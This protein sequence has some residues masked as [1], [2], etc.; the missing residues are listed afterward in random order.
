MCPPSGW[1]HTRRPPAVGRA[2]PA[3]FV[4]PELRL[5]DEEQQGCMKNLDENKET[6]SQPER[7]Q[8]KS[9]ALAMAS[10][11]SRLLADKGFGQKPIDIVEALAFAMFVIADTYS[12]AKPDKDRARE[13]IHGFYGDMQNYFIQ[14]VIIADHQMSDATEIQS[15]SDQFHDLSRDRFGQYGEKFKQ[16]ISDPMALSCPITVSSLLDNL[17]IQPITKQEKLELMGAV[18]DRVL[19][20]WTG[21]VQ[22]FT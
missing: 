20:F 15:V 22:K 17:F 8:L 7:K 16:D 14:K 6:N 2:L 19:A 5:G 18:S 10:D 21:C 4:V 12:L 11:I 3:I 1:A 9:L 13:V